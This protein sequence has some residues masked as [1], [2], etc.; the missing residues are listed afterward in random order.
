M[1]RVIVY[2]SELEV[3]SACV[4]E[5]PDIETGGELFG[6]WTSKGDLVVLV[7]PLFYI[8]YPFVK[9]W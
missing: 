1:D 8:F 3:L 9:W 4:M 5:R 2:Q 7:K 6:F